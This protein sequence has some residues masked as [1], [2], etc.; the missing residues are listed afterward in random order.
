M[1]DELAK[2]DQAHLSTRVSLSTEFAV[3]D[4]IGGRY[5]VI[6]CIGRGGMGVVYKVEQVF[7][8][9]QLALKTLLSNQASDTSIRRF[10]LEGKATFNLDHPNLISVTDLGILDDGTPFLVMEFIKGHTLA[11]HL[12]AKGRLPYKEAAKLFARVCLGL[13]HA[14]NKGIVHRDIKPSNLMLTGKELDAEDCV[15]VMDFGIAKIMRSEVQEAQA[16][17]KT[18]EVIGSPLYMSPEQCS[19][20]MVDFRS[21]IYSLGC[22]FFECL[23][24]APPFIGDTA[25]STITKHLSESPPTLKDASLGI[26]FPPALEAMV[27][28]MLAKDPEE[29]YKDLGHVAIELATLI[30][31]DTTSSMKGPVDGTNVR[32]KQTTQSVTIGKKAF[33]MLLAAPLIAAAVAGVSMY[34]LCMSDNSDMTGSHSRSQPTRTSSPVPVNEPRADDYEGESAEGTILKPEPP[35]AR[36]VKENGQ[37]FRVFHFGADRFGQLLAMSDLAYGKTRVLAGKR[38]PELPSGDIMVPAAAPVKLAVNLLDVCHHPQWLDRFSSDD[39]TG[40]GILCPGDM[41]AAFID[42]EPRLPD[43]SLAFAS[44]LKS[45]Q[46]LDLSKVPISMFGLKEMHIDEFTHLHYLWLGNTRV[47]GRELSKLRSLLQQLLVLDIRYVKGASNVLAAMQGS[48]NMLS[49]CVQGDHLTNTDLE[50]ISSMPNLATVALA[51]NNVTDQGLVKLTRLK[52][53]EQ[54]WMKD[55]PISSASVSTLSKLTELKVLELPKKLESIAPVLQQS[56]P[57]CRITCD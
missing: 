51:D 11:D 32:P 30:R 23:T 14:H 40:L 42:T 52:H 43:D 12:R 16:L 6:S 55:C 15:K 8:G 5:R 9:E 3:G 20:T 26:E 1:P 7:I 54:L 24:G 49:L 45:L 17:T 37:E 38:V 25:L 53:L 22:V 10:Q 47:D 50:Y 18:G 34:H 41:G 21:D 46:A 29:R 56:L 33:A 57:H 44:H 2:S 39:L 19:G 13:A 35:F 31:D 4:V 48:K 27:A 36:V 28:K